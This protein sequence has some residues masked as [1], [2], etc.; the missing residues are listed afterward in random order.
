MIRALGSLVCASLL[1]GAA[2]AQH[3]VVLPIGT[4][5]PLAT[6]DPLSS[7]TGVKGDM[8]RLRTTADVA[9]DG[10]VAI[11]AGTAATGQIVDARAKGAMGMSGRLVVRP[12][13]LTV[14]AVTVRLSGAT[15]DKG[16]VS[17][18]AVIATVAT[19]LPAFTGQSAVIPAGTQITGVVERTAT[20]PAI[21]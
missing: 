14:G 16:S 13:Y 15:L 18:G 10:A 8:V 17:A 4:T 9:V 20:L 6:L 3:F 1:A 7:K 19:A 5:V 21:P 2:I 12:L 11:P